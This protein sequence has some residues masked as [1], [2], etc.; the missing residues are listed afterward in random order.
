MQR[1]GFY[2]FDL[3]DDER[4]TRLTNLANNVGNHYFGI[5]QSPQGNRYKPEYYFLDYVRRIRYSLTPK[6]SEAM[7]D[8]MLTYN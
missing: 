2:K 1:F 8:Y 6:G 4:A 7:K 5:F 3:D